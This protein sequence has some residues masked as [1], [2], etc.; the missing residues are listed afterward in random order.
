MLITVDHL[1]NNA[2]IASICMFEETPD[3]SKLA[4]TMVITHL[5]QPF[6]PFYGFTYDHNDNHVQTST[7]CL[8]KL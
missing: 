8:E 7:F 3:V 2:G 4:P 6:D 1:V 5:H